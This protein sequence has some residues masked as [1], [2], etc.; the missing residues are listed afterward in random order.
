MEAAL[1]VPMILMVLC[2]RGLYIL[3]K[4]TSGKIRCK[5]II[6][7]ILAHRFVGDFSDRVCRICGLVQERGSAG[8]LM[9]DG[10]TWYDKGYAET[11]IELVH[12]YMNKIRKRDELNAKSK[13][14][15]KASILRTKIKTPEETQ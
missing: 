13:E 3:S 5:G 12:Y 8:I 2:V 14:N 6:G 7:L 9:S 15:H 1:I 4:E 11:K 10:D